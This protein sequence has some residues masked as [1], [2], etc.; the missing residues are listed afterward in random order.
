[1]DII[2]FTLKRLLTRGF[3]LLV[4]STFGSVILIALRTKYRD[5]I[6]SDAAATI[7]KRFN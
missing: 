6:F 4:L 2:L 3:W 7:G 5:G 1:M